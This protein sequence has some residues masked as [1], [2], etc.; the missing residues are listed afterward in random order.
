MN[1]QTSAVG[2]RDVVIV[3]G[4]PVGMGLAIELGQRNVSVTVVERYPQP[5]D[6]LAVLFR[7]ACR[8]G[9]LVSRAPS[10][11]VRDLAEYGHRLG[12]AFQMVDDL[13][14]YTQ[15]TVVLGKRAGADLREGK[16][17][18][19]VIYALERA[20]AEDARWMKTMIGKT[21]FSEAEFQRLVTA[22]ETYGGIPYTHQCAVEHI[23][24][25][26]SALAGFSSCAERDILYD[27]AEYAL[28]RTA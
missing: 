1:D 20:D 21:D 3:G 9:A 12:M 13:L 15:D 27:I 4:G 2:V 18:L 28:S 16:L 26:K 5:E 19:P 17:T 7:G 11:H 23:T 6:G 10:H 22:L 14:D 24:A 25:A 8:T